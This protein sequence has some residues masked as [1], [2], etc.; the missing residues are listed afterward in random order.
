MPL[1]GVCLL[2]ILCAPFSDASRLKTQRL[3]GTSELDELQNSS[4][5]GA[6]NSSQS[7]NIA[8]I[9]SQSVGIDIWTC[10]KM[11]MQCP[12]G[13][14]ILIQRQ[15]SGGA[16]IVGAVTG[17]VSLGWGMTWT[18]QL[19]GCSK[20]GFQFLQD[21]ELLEEQPL[22]N[23]AWG[24]FVWSGL[25][26]LQTRRQRGNAN[27]VA[28]DRQAKK[29][30]ERLKETYAWTALRTSGHADSVREEQA[31]SC[32]S[33]SDL[34]GSF[35]DADASLKVAR[36]NPF[37]DESMCQ[38]RSW[39]PTAVKSEAK[40]GSRGA[41]DPAPSRNMKRPGLCRSQRDP[42]LAREELQQSLSK[43]FG[44]EDVKK[45][46]SDLINEAV[47]ETLMEQHAPANMQPTNRRQNFAFLGPPGTGK[48][49]IGKMLS[50]AFCKLGRVDHEAFLEVRPDEL[51]GEYVGQTQKKVK[52]RLEPGLGG[53]IFIDEAYLLTSGGAHGPNQFQQEAIGVLM[54]LLDEHAEDTVFV[55]A[56]YSH[57]MEGFFKTNDGLKRR[58]P[59][60]FRFAPM[61]VDD[62]VSILKLKL[63]IQGVGL[64]PDLTQDELE[65]LASEYAQFAKTSSQLLP[66][67]GTEDV[68]KSFVA[69]VKARIGMVEKP[70]DF[71][72]E[73]TRSELFKAGLEPPFDEGLSSY[74]EI[75]DKEMKALIESIPV[76]MREKTNGGLIDMILDAAWRALAS[77]IQEDS[78]LTTEK[79]CMPNSRLFKENE[80]DVEE[81]FENACPPLLFYSISDMSTAV[82]AAIK[83][84]GTDDSEYSF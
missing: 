25:E 61:S 57:D 50:K 62:L 67:P 60:I 28:K 65:A 9:S 79:G 12:D 16:N 20:I 47:L 3:F 84:W 4:Q 66:A 10:D 55:F 73:K 30:C 15:K 44:L 49:T 38:A 33:H 37:A 74:E 35:V 69:Y 46:A 75:V 54:K 48:T 81:L 36:W 78:L 42:E 19:A 5:A 29:A 52:E 56:G 41:S 26:K 64:I 58:I 14:N 21:G 11:C 6:S 80:N 63:M 76:G 24:V 27:K 59:Q 32:L 40:D 39:F 31:R 23:Q 82:Q 53:V 17:A 34:C 22:E 43:T 70:A 77:R 1:H 18:T 68:A 7:M 13:R 2:I 71:L 45:A 51:I 8:S 72:Q 83:S